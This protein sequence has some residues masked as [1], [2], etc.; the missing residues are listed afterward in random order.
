[1]SKK[2]EFLKL[3]NVMNA[4]QLTQHAEFTPSFMKQTHE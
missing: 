1:M 2:Y 3:I 4:I